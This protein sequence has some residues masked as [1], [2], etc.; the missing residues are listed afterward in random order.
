MG[1]AISD[2]SGHIGTPLDDAKRHGHTAV[3]DFLLSR[4]AV[5]SSSRIPS[6][7]AEARRID[8]GRDALPA[9]SAKG[10]GLCNIL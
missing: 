8:D 1:S 4:G 5:A 3:V 7:S 10:S 9:P 6:T 2:R